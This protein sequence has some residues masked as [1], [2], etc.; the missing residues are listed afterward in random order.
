M[1][2]TSTYYPDVSLT[3][4]YTIDMTWQSISQ[5]YATDMTDLTCLR[6]LGNNFE[7]LA[8]SYMELLVRLWMLLSLKKWFGINLWPQDTRPYNSFKCHWPNCVPIPSIAMVM[9]GTMVRGWLVW[10]P[11]GPMAW[12][13]LV[14][15]STIKLLPKKCHAGPMAC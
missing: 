3:T 15:I 12:L 4:S 7:T 14:R 5:M 1:V 6:G 9:G 10:W 11:T 8:S 13:V 2:P